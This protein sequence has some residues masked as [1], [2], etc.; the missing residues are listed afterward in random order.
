MKKTYRKG[1]FVVVYRLE[2]SKDSIEY[3]ILKRKLHWKGWEFCKGGIE[4]KEALK[5]AALREVKEEVGLKPLNIKKH[6]KSGKY[7]YAKE[8]RDR[9]GIIGQ[10]YVLFSSEVG[11]GNVKYNKKDHEHSDYKWCSF[12]QALKKLSYGNQRACLRVV[13][14]KLTKQ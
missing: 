13:D 7:K 6:N 2:K 3:L 11:Q 9:P 5:K 12:K 4:P 8:F 1:I 14:K 10:T